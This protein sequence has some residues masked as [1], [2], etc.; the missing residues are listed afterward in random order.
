MTSRLYHDPARESRFS[1][2]KKLLLASKRQRNVKQRK[3]PAEIKDFLERQDA[4]TLHRPVR[5]RIPRNP[6]N[7]NNILDVWE[8][9][10]LDFHSVNLTTRINLY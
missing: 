10:L 5:K 2:Y 9:D 4:Y 8:C 3:T 6:Y 7:V 1:S